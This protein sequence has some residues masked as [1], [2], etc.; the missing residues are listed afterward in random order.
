MVLIRPSGGQWKYKVKLISEEPE[1]TDTITI[2]STLNKT[3]QVSFK[4]ENKSKKSSVFRAFFQDNNTDS[5]DGSAY[6]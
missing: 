2:Y 1:I 6:M 4:L 5:F 3:T